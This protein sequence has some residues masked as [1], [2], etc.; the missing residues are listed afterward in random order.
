MRALSGHKFEEPTISSTPPAIEISTPGEII[1]NI[2]HTCTLSKL[3]IHTVRELHPPLLSSDA[4]L[5]VLNTRVL[6]PMGFSVYLSP[7][8]LV[9][10]H[11][12]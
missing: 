11:L 12:A 4:L 3:P 8:P 2:P 6:V 7:S 10:S 1:V 5:M 9:S